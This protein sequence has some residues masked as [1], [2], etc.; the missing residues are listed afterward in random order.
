MADIAGAPWARQ[1]F[2]PSELITASVAVA[3]AAAG[4][5]PPTNAGRA[6]ENGIE[7]DAA[8]FT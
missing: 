6:K 4:R 3:S 7:L 8:C 2:K 1:W 5:S